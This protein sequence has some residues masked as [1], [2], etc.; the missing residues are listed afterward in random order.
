MPIVEAVILLIVLVLL[1]NI[2]SHY[3][4][5][6]PVSLIQ[7]ALG[8]IVALIWNFEIQLETDWF[9]LLF[10]APLLYNDGRRFPRRELWRLRGPIFANAIWLVFLTTILGGYLIY[11]LIP[12]MPLTV[13]FALAAILSPTDPVAVQSISK[14]AKLPENLMHLVSGESLINDASGLIAFKYAIAATV[15]GAFSMGTAVGD[16]VYISIVGF[17]A[18]LI[19]M[20]AI[21]LL[22]DV[23]RRQGIDDVVFNTV[24]QIATPFVIYLVTEEITHASGVIAVVTAGVLYHARESQVV[25]DS[26]ELKLVT[27]KVWDIIIYSL[28]G[29]VFVILGI[30]LPVATTQVIKGGQFNTGE[31]LLFALGTWVIILALR[32]IWTYG[33][34]IFQRIRNHDAE[35]P[36]FRMAILSGLSGVRGA[37]TMAGVLSVPLTIASGAGFPTRSLMLFVASGVI[38]ISLLAATITLPLI[39]TSKQPLQTRASASD[40]I[41]NELDLDDEDDDFRD[42]D[43][44]RQI[45]EDE[46]RAY[47]MRL[48]ISKIEELRR[49]NN[50]RAAYDLIL[51]YQFVIRRLEMSYR[52][53]DTMQKV[54]NDELQLRQVAVDGEREALKELRQGEKITQTSYVGALRRIERLESRLTQASGHTWPSVVRYWILFFKHLGRN[55]AYWLHSEDTDRLHAESNLIERETAKAAIKSLS[56]YLARTDI[57]ETQ[58]DNQAIYHLIVN[59]RNRIER[60]KAAAQPSHEDEYQHQFSKLRIRALSAERAGIQ[61]LLEAGNITWTMATH[62]RQYVNY[63]ENVLVMSLNDEESN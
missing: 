42:A 9:L 52:A 27:E 37:V 7:I 40:D 58:F 36:S 21:Q 24:L 23:L 57:D 55:A 51:D 43:E 19:M 48:A 35:Q 34:I 47:I 53:D 26:P 60:A 12:K 17:L 56:Q 2:I 4:T 50:Q 11:W 31:A 45:S 38:I 20:T 46:A 41:T 32:T 54:L 6:I 15:T 3:L 29:I 8:L 14:Q 5:F 16:F 63:A 62:L 49:P 1:S 10:I 33:Y 13:A 28:N 44:V 39:S 30:E 61:T 18:G 25:E 59:Y 22:M